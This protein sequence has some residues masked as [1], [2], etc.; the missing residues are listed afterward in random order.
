MET[1]TLI[2]RAYTFLENVLFQYPK[3]RAHFRI[4]FF[5][6]IALFLVGIAH[7]VGFFNAGQWSMIAFDWIKESVYLNTLREAQLRGVIPW[8]WSRPIYHGLQNVFANPEITLTPDIILLRWVSNS[9]FVVIHVILFYTVGFF[10]S[11]LIVEKLKASFVTFLFL[12]LVFNFNGY[13][14]SHLAVGHFQWTG[15]FL[16]PF[17]FITL[18]KFIAESQSTSSIN[19]RYVIGMALILGVLFLNGSFHFAIWC[20]VFL[21]TTLLWRSAMFSNVVAAII[22]GC[23]L[24]FGRLLPA[25]LY[26]RETR[27]LISG[28]TSIVSLLD[29]FTTLRG[30]DTHLWWEFDI[31][32][33][34]VAFIILVLCFALALKRSNLVFQP[35]FFATAGLFLV[36]SLGYVYGLIANRPFPFAGIE[37]VPSRF[38]VMPFIL[39]LITAMTGVEELF[40][41][42]PKTGRVAVLIAMPFVAYE[43][44][45]HSLHWRVERLNRSFAEVTRPALTLVP[46]S[47]QMYALSVY[48]GWTISFISLGVVVVL[49]LRN[50]QAFKR[51]LNR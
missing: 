51:I 23:L 49:L 37:R 50:H 46:N 22:I 27:I 33:G 17:F 6:S 1:M 25:V 10:G 4:R 43:L 38:I 40:R 2:V 48:V 21:A 18:S 12:W 39:F 9:I 15:Y 20:L 14:I 11:L 30:H 42:W 44:A 41:S 31:Y 29:A 34:F 32:I 3:T 24:A 13:L 36:L 35:P 19:I 7:W 5:L 45:S 16:L 8:Q 26:I 28:Y 47:D